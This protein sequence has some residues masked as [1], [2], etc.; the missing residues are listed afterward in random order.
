[1]KSPRPETGSVSRP[2][3]GVSARG[4]RAPRGG[5]KAGEALGDYDRNMSRGGFRLT[6]QR[7]E[8][9]DALL[10]QRDHPTA[11]DLFLRVK[12]RL[13]HISLAT[14]YNCLETLVQTG[15][16]RQVTTGRGPARYCPN[17]REHGHFHCTRCGAV[18]DVALPGEAK[19]LSGLGLPRGAVV[20]GHEL[21]LH[22]LCPSCS[23]GESGGR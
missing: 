9:Y 20:T 14:V 8:V 3:R 5:G 16:V 21:T 12:D 19:F 7:R 23:A 13:P 15:L 18:I 6:R 4:G 11:S 1:M 17:L 2:R 10:Q 22:G